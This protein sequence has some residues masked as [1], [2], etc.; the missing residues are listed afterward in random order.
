MAARKAHIALIS[1]Y[2][3]DAIG[4][5]YL[6]SIL[7]NYG[8]KVSL[9]LFKE[10]YLAA[11]SMT[12]PTRKEYRFLVDLLKRLNPDMVGLSLRSSYFKIASQITK[13]IKRELSI[14]V[15]WGGTH[16]TIAPDESIQVAD[17][18]CLG[19]G[20]YPLLEL[21]EK[22]SSSQH[23]SHIKNLWIRKDGR[24]IKNEVRPLIK[25]LDSLPFPD[26]GDKNKYFIEQGV[27]SSY[28][29]GL[30]TYNLNI[31]ASRG[32]P[33]HCSYCCNSIFNAI[34]HKK[35]PRIRR[36]SVENVME[37]IH[38]LMDRFPRL[39]RV[40][41]ID[42]VFA[43]DKKWTAEFIE[44]YRNEVG[45][46]FHC[47][48]HPNMVNKEILKLLKEA[49]L[50][51]V[52][53]G[54]QSGSERIRREYFERPVSDRRLLQN[55]RLLKEMGIVPFYDFIVD[56]PFESEEDKRQGLEFLLQFP[57]PFHLHVF[58][59]IFFPNTIITKRALSAH[60]I[61]ED[62]VESRAQQTFEQMFVTLRYPRPKDNQFWISLY[63]LASKSFI[64]KSLIRWL[65][66][67]DFLRK[68]PKILVLFADFANTL[69]LSLIAVKW[70]WEG[71]PVFSTIRQTAR[72]GRSPII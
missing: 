63:S 14:P 67:R 51:R 72:R 29:P 13:K 15:I 16:P 50:E 65:S 48:Q 17:M 49:G 30:Q 11:D 9:I 27:K 62:Q 37:E 21:A 60:L 53:V 4:I 35:G 8:H 58:S 24:I 3:T 26:Y 54:V 52:E 56:N 70:L 18:I 45:L 40:D 6:S 36:R 57:R 12:L 39:R 34:Y 66:H 41:F 10:L 25:D 42:E 44:C 2:S 5:R 43:W 1:L 69:K 33:Y 71:K 59:L 7:N 55:S 23:I 46:P 32:C 38:A 61:S 47:A 20:E 64:S 19:E 31:L 28:D 68:H 22:I